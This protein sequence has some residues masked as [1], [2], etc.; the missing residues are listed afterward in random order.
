MLAGEAAIAADGVGM[1]VDQPGRLADAAALVDVLEEGEGLVLGQVG[2]IQRC[3]L[4]LGE[5]GAAA[6]AIEQ[7]KLPVLAKSAG[8]GEIS[9]TAAAEVGAVGIEATELG[10]I[11]HGAMHG[12]E[13]EVR[14]GLET[15][16]LF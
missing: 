5:A 1:D 8:D 7:A 11:V 12:L 16:L 14:K 10:E 9:G 2:A 4:A 15:L 3:A 13:A 6:A